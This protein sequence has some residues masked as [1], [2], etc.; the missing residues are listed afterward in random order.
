M[1][2]YIGCD[3]GTL[4]ED[5]ELRTWMAML[6]KAMEIYGRPLTAG[7]QWKQVMEEAG[8]EDVV[9]TVYKWP[10]N[11]WPKDQKHK[12]LGRWSQVNMGQV[13]DGALAPLTRALGWTKEEV[14]VLAAKAKKDLKD[15][16][17]HAYWPM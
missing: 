8:F 5:S 3:D 9:E 7:Q 16:K 15:P 2:A 6:C 11:P 12:T 10:T 17:I 13:L 1:A 14:V 4:P